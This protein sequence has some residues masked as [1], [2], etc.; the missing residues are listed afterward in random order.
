MTVTSIPSTG[1]PTHTPRPCS[2]SAR[3]SLRI[4]ALEMFATGRHSVAP[5]GVKIDT[6]AGSSFVNF[7]ST[8]GVAGAPALIT[9]RRLA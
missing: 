5:Y 3:V 6:P 1:F 4:S 8:V 7:S 9:R 2:V